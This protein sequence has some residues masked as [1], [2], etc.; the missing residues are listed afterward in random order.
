MADL[1]SAD[2]TITVEDRSIEGKKKRN[3][4]KLVFGDGVKTYPAGGVPL[5]TFNSFG[6]VRNLDL[7]NITDESDADGLM[8]KYDQENNKIRI[9]FPTQQTASSGDREGVEYTG[10]TTVVAATTMYAEAVGW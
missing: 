3:R 7:I 2:V 1:T 5:P 4:V 6:M 9:W 8:Y 10:A